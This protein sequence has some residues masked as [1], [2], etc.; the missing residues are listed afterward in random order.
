MPLTT[1]QRDFV[2]FI[3]HWWFSHDDINQKMPTNETLRDALNWEG[4]KVAKF[5]K[6]PDVDKALENRG[7]TLADVTLLLPEQL[8]VANT[9][10]DFSDNRSQKKKLEELGVTTQRYQ[11]WLKQERFQRYMRQRAEAL[12]GETQHEAH[13]SLLRNVQ[14]GDLNSIK[15]YYEMT[16][17]WSSKTAGDLNVEFILIKV[18]EAVQK[19]VKDPVAIQHIAHE[20]SGL[21]GSNQP[22]S[23]VPAPAPI[24]AEIIDKPEQPET[25]ALF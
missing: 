1:D 7:I 9:I 3:E 18:V 15:L 8:A 19:Y 22:A 21:V 4:S 12:L 10:L 2:N 23:N 6:D 13:T 20:L 24:T 11:G 16:G 14:R 5:L 17:R 25:L